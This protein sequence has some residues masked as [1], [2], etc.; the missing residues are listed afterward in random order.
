M[1]PLVTDEELAHARRDSA[2]RH[3]LLIENLNRLL[4]ALNRLRKKGNAN[5]GEARQIRE[6][7]DLAVQLASRLQH[8]DS[9]S[10]A[11]R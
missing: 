3:H 5:P 8:D 11:A 6:G 7:V 9:G 1:G 4:N 2:F 10:Q